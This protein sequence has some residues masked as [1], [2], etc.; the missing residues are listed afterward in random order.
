MRY[1]GARIACAQQYI[2]VCSDILSEHAQHTKNIQ[3]LSLHVTK[4]SHE[5]I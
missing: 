3:S 2:T 4:T 1:A 5:Y